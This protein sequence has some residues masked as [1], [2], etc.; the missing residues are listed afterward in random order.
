MKRRT[1]L[2]GRLVILAGGISSRMKKNSVGFGKIDK[3]LIHD[4]DN[5]SKF[6]IGVGKDCRPFLDYLLFN[7]RQSGYSDI[8]I[9]IGQYDNSIKEY[10]GKKEHDNNFKGLNISYTVQPIPEG[11]EKPLGTADALCRG[12]I[13]KPEWRGSKFTV[14][15][16]DNLYSQKALKLMLNSE[17]KN[18]MIDYDIEEFCIS[19]EQIRNYAVTRKNGEGFISEI[20]EKPS[21]ETIDE[22]KQ[23]DGYIGVSMNIFSLDYD[24]VLPV[25]ANVPINQA[26]NEKELP[27]AVMMMADLFKNSVYAYTL[28]EHVPDLTSKKDIL[29]VKQYLEKE[30]ADI[31]F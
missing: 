12:I 16:S 26:R 18:A 6:M 8:V 17:Y 10:Y 30:F 25:L 5:K 1:D 14:C 24:M 2:N 28:K 11:R 27:T 7:A 31:D 3:D 22:I 9:V 4:A 29:P 21:L 23:K 15:N 13:S 19:K 20:I